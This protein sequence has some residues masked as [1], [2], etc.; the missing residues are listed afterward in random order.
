MNEREIII[1]KLEQ[2]IEHM[3]YLYEPS[4]EDTQASELA[5]L[6]DTLRD[7]Q[8]DFE[9]WVERWKGFGPREVTRWSPL[10]SK[11]RPLRLPVDGGRRKK[12]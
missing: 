11:Q 12:A 6:V 5:A 8:E 10:S 3:E 4:D 1:E 9:K 7:V 2:A